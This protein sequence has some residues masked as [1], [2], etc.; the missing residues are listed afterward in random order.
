MNATLTT[1]E[2]GRLE[3]EVQDGRVS[4][5]DVL[6]AGELRVKTTDTQP[7]AASQPVAIIR[8]TGEDVEASFHLTAG[9]VGDVID[10]LEE[11]DLR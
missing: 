2:G 6:E 10:A 9:A 4:V 8:L 7:L 11:V 1:I 3:A 5:G